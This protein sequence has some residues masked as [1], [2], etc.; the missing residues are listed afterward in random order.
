MNVLP[1]NRYLF[2]IYYFFYLIT[3][4]LEKTVIGP[5]AS[6]FGFLRRIPGSALKHLRINLFALLLLRQRIISSYFFRSYEN[7][8]Q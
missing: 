1:L 8:I 7:R 3:Q 6:C 4:P 5:S 2:I